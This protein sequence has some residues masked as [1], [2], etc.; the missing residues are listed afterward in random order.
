MDFKKLNE[1]LQKFLPMNEI[2]LETKARAYKL[3]QQRQKEKEQELDKPK[4]KLQYFRSKHGIKL[5]FAEWFGEDLTGKTYKGNI[6]CVG[7]G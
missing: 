2:S 3:R 4:D 1:E 5:T 7:V 6:K